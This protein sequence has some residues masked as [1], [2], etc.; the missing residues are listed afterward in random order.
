LLCPAVSA[1]TLDAPKVPVPPYKMARVV[2][3]GV[4]EVAFDITPL[5]ATE[6]D[7]D[8]YTDGLTYLFTAGPGRY[9]VSAFGIKAG[10]PA[11]LSA[12][13]VFA[14]S[15]PVPPGPTPPGPTPV[16]PGPTPPGPTP[17]SVSHVWTTLVFDDIR[18]TPE[19]AGFTGDPSVSTRMGKSGV[20]QQVEVDSQEY[21]R[22]Q[23]AKIVSDAGG[24]P[25]LIYQA[26]DGKVL[27]VE[28]PTTVE[29]M[30]NTVKRLTGQ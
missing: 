19:V 11:I 25:T 21:N 23:L 22:R 17:P 16:P 18:L 30:L 14:G 24:V 26:D 9:K 5:G 8:A 29:A 1:Q 20:Y 6:G 4:D 3:D 7:Y 27:L 15:T 10:K 2:V 13:V 12:V 28:R